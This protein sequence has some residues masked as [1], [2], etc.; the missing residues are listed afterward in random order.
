MSKLLKHLSEIYQYFGYENI[1]ICGGLCDLYWI[2][3]QPLADIDIIVNI[4]RIKCFFDTPQ[5][6]TQIQ[7][8][9]FNLKK[10]HYSWPKGLA[11][12]SGEFIKDFYQG[13][14]NGTKIDLFLVENISILNRDT[15]VVNGSKLGLDTI[16]IDSIQQRINVLNSQLYYIITD[17]TQQ[18][19][20]DWIKLKKIKAEQKLAIYN[21]KTEEWAVDKTIPVM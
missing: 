21:K 8:C 4:D 17:K 20:K 18:W 19:E 2:N 5:L 15:V 16:R 9:N 13:D 14:Y 12:P 11:P 6:T 1:S 10:R 3:Y 7:E